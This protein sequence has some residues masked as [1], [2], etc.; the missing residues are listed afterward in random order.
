MLSFRCVRYIIFIGRLFNSYYQRIYQ[1]RKCIH[2][3]LWILLYILVIDLIALNIDYVL[4]LTGS[5]L[6]IVIREIWIIV[7]LITDC[8]MAIFT[9]I[10]FFRPICHSR[11]LIITGDNMIIIRRYGIISALQL[12]AAVLYELSCLVWICLDFFLTS[13]DVLKAY[14]YICNVIQMI[15]CLLLM[16]CIYFGFARGQTVCTEGYVLSSHIAWMES[17]FKTEDCYTKD[18]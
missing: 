1:Y 3:F 11:N 16:I 7:F 9:T 10:L 18:L 17:T 2:Q 5:A 8:V 4:A 12:F 13:K 15:D 14:G 6:P